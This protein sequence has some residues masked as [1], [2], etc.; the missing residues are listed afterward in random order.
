VRHTCKT[1][2]DCKRVMLVDPSIV[3]VATSTTPHM[4]LLILKLLIP[5]SQSSLLT[6]PDPGAVTQA[7]QARAELL[8]QNREEAAILVNVSTLAPQ[9][10]YSTVREFYV[11][12]ACEAYTDFVHISLATACVAR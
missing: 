11:R 6:V 1:S 10:Q 8:V 4:K 7:S 9:T 5:A 12:T 2:T 3:A